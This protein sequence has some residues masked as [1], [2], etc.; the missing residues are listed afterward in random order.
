MSKAPFSV[1]FGRSAE[2][3][4]EERE[5]LPLG[6][7]CWRSIGKR[8]SSLLRSSFQTTMSSPSLFA[9]QKP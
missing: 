7:A 4:G 9:G 8:I 2:D 1:D 6:T 3:Y 5:G